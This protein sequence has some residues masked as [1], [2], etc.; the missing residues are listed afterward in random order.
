MRW[1]RNLAIRRKLMLLVLLPCGVALLVAATAFISYDWLMYRQTMI[2]EISVLADVLG[3]N[4]TAALSFNARDTA[5]EMLA[6]LK[7]QPHI[8]TACLYDK[9]GRIFA[10]YAQPHTDAHVPAQV[11]LRAARFAGDRLTLFQPIGLGGRLVGTIYLESDLTE[12]TER[13]HLYIIVVTAKVLLVLLVV[14]GLALKLQTFVSRPI[15]RLATTARTVSEQHDYSLRVEKTT[16]DEL[17]EL[18][19]AFNEMLAQIQ[20]SDRALQKAHD[21]LEERVIQRTEELSKAN[22]ALQLEISERQSAEAGL[23]LKTEALAHSNTELEQ[24]AYVASHDLQ[25]PLR[26]VSSYLQLVEQR[27]AGKLDTEATEFINYA[28][29]GA[30]RMR[31]LIRDLLEYS[32]VGRRQQSLTPV[33]CETVFHNVVQSL[34]QAIIDTHATVTAD[35]LPT[36]LADTTEF[37]Q[38][39]QNLIGNAIKFHG[40]RP[41]TVHVEASRQDGY[42]QFAVRDNGIGIE[43]EYFEKVFVIFQR[44]H[45]RTDYPGTGLGLA[46]CKKII[47]RYGGRIWIESTAGQGTTFFF[48]LPVNKEKEATP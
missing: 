19:T 28:V 42:W 11:E 7:A 39:L 16:E 31:T 18:T 3:N 44:L 29:D 23:R 46:I 8:V 1:L 35:P 14:F 30:A 2:R 17:G 41:P 24:F 36:V 13:L 22:A 40:P 48:T 34:Q 27:Y 12:L 26:M 5:E 15:L 45:S 32:R 10:T 6:A 20:R 43:P 21:D 47:D 25:E 4:S 9:Q 33:N 38:L 37:T